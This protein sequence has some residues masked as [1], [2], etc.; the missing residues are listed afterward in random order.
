M[1]GVYILDFTQNRDNGL[2]T[3]QDKLLDPCWEYEIFYYES[4]WGKEFKKDLIY[5][6]AAENFP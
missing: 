2:W 6:P 3:G 4:Q 1:E 5:G